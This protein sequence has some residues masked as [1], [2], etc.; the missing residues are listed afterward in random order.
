MEEMAQL[1]AALPSIPVVLRILH[2]CRDKK[3]PID[4]PHKRLCI[5]MTECRQVPEIFIRDVGVEGDIK[6]SVKSS[7]VHRNIRQFLFDQE[8]YEFGMSED[9]A[10]SLHH[11]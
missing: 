8:G 7:D 9:L 2:I 4:L 3:T 10:N 5:S 1:L 11:R 6:Q